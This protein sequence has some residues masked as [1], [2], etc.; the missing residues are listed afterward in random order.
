MTNNILG[1]KAIVI[2]YDHY[3]PLGLIRS[4]GEA[5]ISPIIILIG[6]KPYLITKSKYCGIIHKVKNKEDAITFLLQHYGQEK[7]PP[8]VFTCNDK[9]QSAV[10]DNYDKL[11]DHFIFFNSGEKG[12]TLKFMDKHNIMLAATEV[13]LT[14]PVGEVVSRG[15]L[16][17]KVPYPVITKSITSTSGGWKDDVYICQNESELLSAFKKIKSE[18]VLVEEYIKKKNEL[19]LDGISINNGHDV[20]IPLKCNYIRSSNKSYGNYMTMSL[21]DDKILEGKIRK[22]FELIGFS[23]IFSIEFLMTE[24]DKLIF[25]EINF[26]H[27][28]WGYSSTYAGANLPLLWATSTLSKKLEIENVKIRQEPFTAMN[29]IADFKEFV[30]TNSVGFF[31]WLYEFHNCPCT[32]Y[33][34]KLDKAP[35]VAKLLHY[36]R[37][38]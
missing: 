22:L 37:I 14:V 4:L 6:T 33:Y 35:F 20:Y 24:D 25:L 15:S 23:G 21:F 18:T 3:N 38:M 30:L 31:K 28:T 9:S 16:P 10:D 17:K 29:E 27:S 32:Y 26:R 36:L 19:C 12:R 13:G 2:C 1:H 5:G 34:N 11:I 8:F 7:K